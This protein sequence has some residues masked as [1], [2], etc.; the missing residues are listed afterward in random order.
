MICC[1]T[2]RSCLPH[3]T[4]E[5]LLLVDGNLGY[6]CVVPQQ[7]MKSLGA[8]VAISVCLKSRPGWR[9]KTKPIRLK[10]SSEFSR[11]RQLWAAP[12]RTAQEHESQGRAENTG[13]H[14]T[15]Q[16]PEG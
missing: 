10:D 6:I 12:L 15:N 16:E 9:G 8:H 3:P 5:K 7:K 2:H 14:N 4:P 1:Y 11:R 13:E